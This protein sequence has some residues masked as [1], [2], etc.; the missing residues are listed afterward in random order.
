MQKSILWALRVPCLAALLLVVAVAVGGSVQAAQP[1][2]SREWNTFMGASSGDYTGAIAVDGS[3]NVY[4]AGSSWGSWGSPVNVH[5]GEID[6][7]V[8]KLEST[9]ALVW[10]TFMGSSTVD[11]G[12]AIAVDGSGNVYVTGRSFA[13]WGSPVNAHSGDSDAFA[14]KLNASGALQWHTFMGSSESDYGHG[15]ALDGSGNVCVTGHSE[16]SW[17]SPV[18]AHSGGIHPDTFVAKLDGSGALQWNTFMG[19]S[20]AYAI[21][22][23]G[24]G[25]V[26]VAGDSSV[27]WGSPVY[28]YAGGLYDAFAAKLNSSGSLQWN[29][30]MGSDE[31]SGSDNADAIA[32]DGSGGVYV[33]GQ[34]DSAWGSPVNA[35]AGADDAFVT[36]L[37]SNGYRHWNTFMGSSSMDIGNAIAVDGSGNLYVAGYSGASWGSPLNAYTG[38]SEAFAAELDSSGSLQWNTFMGSA[39]LDSRVAIAVDGSENAYV[40]GQSNAS[41]GSPVS[42]HSGDYD[43]FAAKLAAAVSSVPSISFGGLALLA[44]LVLGI[45][46]WARWCS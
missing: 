20:G 7:F 32:V 37:G 11:Q 41:W 6:L 39:L 46:V 42:P 40:A 36:K 35:Y 4:V 5:A 8:A 16:A 14:A 33:V 26:Y 21:A 24:G 29:T 13:S 18:D 2:G 19:P 3:G 34:S 9:G 17:G 44:G 43:V 22:V 27:T 38:N 15:I 12:S 1:K 25:N 23:D 45:M 10:N 28:P 31:S 30:F